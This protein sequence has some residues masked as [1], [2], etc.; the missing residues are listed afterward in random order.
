[1]MSKY[2]D[3][4]NVLEENGDPITINFENKH[5]MKI[6]KILD[7]IKNKYD[8]YLVCDIV[9]GDDLKLL[10]DYIIKIREYYNANVAKYEDLIEKYSNILEENQQLK[11]QKDDVI[12]YIK[13]INLCGF[14][15]GKTFFSKILNNILRMLGEIDNEW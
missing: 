3:I 6:N 9:S 13:S 7:N 8:S 10:L 12:E 1:M 14:R 4:S 2:Y 11:K 15:N 5:I